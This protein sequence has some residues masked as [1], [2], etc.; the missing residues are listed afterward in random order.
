MAIDMIKSWNDAKVILSKLR[1]DYELNNS[2]PR[3]TKPYPNAFYKLLMKSGDYR[4]ITDSYQT[5]SVLRDFKKALTPK[6]QVN[7]IY[8]LLTNIT[9]K[10]ESSFCLHLSIVY[11]DDE[12]TSMGFTNN[13][14]FLMGI[15]FSFNRD[16]LY[17]SP[18]GNVSS[19]RI[20]SPETKAWADDLKRRQRNK[21]S[22]GS[23]YSNNSYRGYSYYSNAFGANDKEKKK[24]LSSPSK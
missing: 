16:G 4:M 13:D 19:P 14:L 10:A 22:N 20:Y 7:F 15:R 5:A 17:Y 1:F 2:I 9:R 3:M 24:N 6:E 21:T 18:S 11:Y 12:L 23:S 8:S